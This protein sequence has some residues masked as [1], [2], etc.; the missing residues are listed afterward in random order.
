MRDDFLRMDRLWSRPWSPAG[1]GPHLP[2]KGRI[3]EIRSESG[4]MPMPPGTANLVRRRNQPRYDLAPAN[5]TEP[6]V[7]PAARSNL[8]ARAGCTPPEA[9][10]RR[11]TGRNLQLRDL[12]TTRTLEKEAPATDVPRIWDIIRGKF[13]LLLTRIT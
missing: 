12:M 8:R 11:R 4:P 7:K 10:A 2:A 9:D 3:I 5:P 1:V 6:F 13:R